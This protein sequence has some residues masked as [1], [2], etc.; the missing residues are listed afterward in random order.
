MKLQFKGRAN[1]V[2]W[3]QNKI[4]TNKKKRTQKELTKHERWT[5]H[6]E[7]KT[8]WHRKKGIQSLNTQEG[9]RQLDTGET[10]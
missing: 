4:K 5:A 7:N 9:G 1:S 3:K 6:W 10:H 2:V 8:I